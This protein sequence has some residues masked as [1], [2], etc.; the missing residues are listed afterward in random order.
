M[1]D[2][3]YHAAHAVLYG[4][5]PGVIPKPEL[6]EPLEAWARFW[7]RIVCSTF[8]DSYLAVPGIAQLMPSARGQQ[9]FLLDIFRLDTALHKLMFHLGRAPERIRGPSRAVIEIVEGA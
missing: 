6:T 3:Y 8:M 2:S 1:L 7:F 9:Q 4:E 5:A